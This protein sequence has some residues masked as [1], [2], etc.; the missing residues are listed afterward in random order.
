MNT[1]STPW[2]P[3]ASYPSTCARRTKQ[4]DGRAAANAIVVQAGWRAAATR[5]RWRPARRTRRRRRRWRAARRIR[6]RRTA[7]WFGPRK[8]E[9]EEAVMPQNRHPSPDRRRR[10]RRKSSGTSAFTSTL[11]IIQPESTLRQLIDVK[12]GRPWSRSTRSRR[13]WCGQPPEEEEEEDASDSICRHSEYFWF[14]REGGSEPISPCPRR[15][16]RIIVFTT[17]RRAG[18]N[19]GG[20]GWSCFSLLLPTRYHHN[21]AIKSPTR[22]RETRASRVTTS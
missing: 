21:S 6:R 2:P 14:K 18:L 17:A 22:T 11:T 7:V 19:G 4:T 3:T 8:T 10:D 13:A 16:E 1:H 12:C 5:R 9:E 20:C 15:H